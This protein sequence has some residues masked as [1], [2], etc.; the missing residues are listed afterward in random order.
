M[1][2]LVKAK[3][4][5]ESR[6]FKGICIPQAN[7]SYGIFYKTNFSDSDL[8]NCNLLCTQFLN[9]NLKGAIL[10]NTGPINE[11]VNTIDRIN[12]AEFSHDGS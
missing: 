1:S 11:Q 7:L 3:C 5:F 4:S 2:I 8:S 9:V 10:P 12:S 6:D